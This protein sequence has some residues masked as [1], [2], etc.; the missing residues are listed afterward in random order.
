MRQFRF[1]IGPPEGGLTSVGRAIG[2]ESSVHRETLRWLNLLRDGRATAVYEL[3]GDPEAVEPHLA[4]APD[5]E[6]AE[7]FAREADRCGLYLLFDPDPAVEALIAV[8][9]R[10]P[11][12]FDLP[13]PFSVDGDLRFTVASTQ[14]TAQEAFA[15]IPD[16]VDVHLEGVGDYRPDWGD[17]RATLTDRQRE[18]LGCAV[19]MGY[20]E[21]PSETSQR[22]IAAELDCSAATVGTHLRKA[23]ATLVSA[24]VSGRR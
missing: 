18:V 1:R 3:R 12:L 24:V 6:E 11:V 14:R 9:D 7:L 22:E 19:E 13:I 21:L 10:Y 4:D 23:E 15:A 8:H 5:V 17:L 2:A 20:Y 16:A